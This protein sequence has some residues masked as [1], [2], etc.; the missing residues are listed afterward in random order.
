M[1]QTL[2]MTQV[3]VDVALMAMDVNGVLLMLP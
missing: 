2:R 1:L 3:I